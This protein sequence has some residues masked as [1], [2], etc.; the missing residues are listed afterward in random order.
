MRIGREGADDLHFRF[1]L[2]VGGIDDAEHGLAA[3]HQRQRGANA[4]P[5]AKFG[6]ARAHRPSFSSAALA[7]L[8]TGTEL[9]SPVAIRPWPASFARSKP[10][11]IVTLLIGESF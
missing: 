6:W 10:D 1:D 2:G 9:T 3:R 8:P 7:Y 11:A 4:S 5:L